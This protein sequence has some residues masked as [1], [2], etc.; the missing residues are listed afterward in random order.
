MPWFIHTKGHSIDIKNKK[1]VLACTD[2]EA[3]PSEGSDVHY[4]IQQGH[5]NVYNVLQLV[6]FKTRLF[7]NL[8][9]IYKQVPIN[10]DVPTPIESIQEARTRVGFGQE[11]RGEVSERPLSTHGQHTSLRIHMYLLNLTS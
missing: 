7:K 4:R 1:I 6:F 10:M 9:Y 5:A 8:I 2:Q 3:R 11:A